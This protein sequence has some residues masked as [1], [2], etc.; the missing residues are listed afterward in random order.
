ML[1]YLF[2]APVVYISALAKLRDNEG[3]RRGALKAELSKEAVF[4]R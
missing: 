1:E 2:R 3:R 4:P